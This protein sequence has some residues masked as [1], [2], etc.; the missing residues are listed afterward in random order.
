MEIRVFSTAEELDRAAAQALLR[1]ILDKPDAVIGLSTGRTTGGIHR[2]FCSL[3]KSCSPD[4]SRVT[5]FGMDEVSG[6]PRDYSGAC[7]TM[8]KTEVID[9][10]GLSEDQ[11]LMLP[12]YADSFPA[13][14]RA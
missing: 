12:T 4:L 1:P 6:V 14:C 7:Y 10:L 3:V 13:A 11:F 8:L 2:A 9:P 5:F